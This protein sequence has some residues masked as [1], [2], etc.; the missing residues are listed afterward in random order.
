MYSSFVK[1]SATGRK[2]IEQFEGLRLK[3]YHDQRGILT[4]GYGHTGPD[5][6]ENSEITQEE[7]DQLLAI[8]LHRAELSVYN[9]VEAAIGQNQFDALVSLIYNIGGG[10]FK[11][12]TVL[13]DLNQGEFQKA[14]DAFLMWCKTNGQTNKGL[15][16]R[17]QAERTL[18]LTPEP[19]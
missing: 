19:V 18:F 17:R 15:L 5:V 11:S 10:A 8:D 6:F 3:A 16:N 7:A 4:I 13:H 2:L 1:T 9:D 12:S 14:A